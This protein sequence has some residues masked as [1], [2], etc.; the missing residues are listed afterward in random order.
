[1]AK[2]SFKNTKAPDTFDNKEIR[3]A[4]LLTEYVSLIKNWLLDS[5]R[6]CNDRLENTTPVAL[7]KVIAMNPDK[8]PERYNMATWERTSC[9]LHVSEGYQKFFTLF[10]THLKKE[11][12]KIGDKTLARELKVLELVIGNDAN[13]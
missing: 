4:V 7:E 10:R 13:S 5:R 12:G 11:M 3:K 9:P 8:R 6:G 1:M 2:A